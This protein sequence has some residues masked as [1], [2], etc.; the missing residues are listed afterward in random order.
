M[1]PKK[2]KMRRLTKEEVHS[3]LRKEQQRQDDKLS[4]GSAS[5]AYDLPNGRLLLV[6][7]KGRGVL[8]ESKDEVLLMLNSVRDRQVSHLLQGRLPQGKDFIA[9]VPQLIDELAVKLK[10]PKEALDESEG[11]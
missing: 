7:E 4:S 2:P 5:I 6:L 3:I 1:K 10:I 11:S 9:Q 8:Y